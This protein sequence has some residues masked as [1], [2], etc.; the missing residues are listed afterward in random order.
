MLSAKALSLLSALFITLG[1]ANAQDSDLSHYFAGTWSDAPGDNYPSGWVKPNE[2]HAQFARE[3]RK[4]SWALP[5]EGMIRSQFKRSAIMSDDNRLKIVN[6][7][8]TICEVIVIVPT[9]V[10]DDDDKKQ[11]MMDEF[12]KLVIHDV[13]SKYKMTGITTPAISPDKSGFA[14]LGYLKS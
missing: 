5:I 2:A 6:C 12:N 7:K 1:A 10:A 3:T 13:G 8:E 11:V 9:A 14:M 4:P